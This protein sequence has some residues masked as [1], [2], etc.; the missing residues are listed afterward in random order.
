MKQLQEFARATYTPFGYSFLAA[1]PEEQVPIPDLRTIGDARLSRPSPDLLETI[2][3]CQSRQA[4]YHD[5]ALMEGGGPLPFVGSVAIG[6]H[7][8]RAATSMRAG[9]GFELEEQA[10]AKSWNDALRSLAR[11]AEEIGILVMTNGVVGSNTHR[12]LDPAEFR[13]FALVDPIAPVVFVNGADTKAAQMF[14]LAHELAHVWAGATALSDVSA[15]EPAEATVER[16]CNAVAAELLVPLAALRGVVSP[17]IGES[18]DEAVLDAAKLLAQRFKVSTLV[19]LRRLFEAEYLAQ[20]RMWSI[21][22]REH[23]RLVAASKRSQG[24]GDYYASKPVRVSRRFAEAIYVSAWE[25]RASFTEAMRLL[26]I[27]KM[28]TFQELGAR[29]GIQV[30]AAGAGDAA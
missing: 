7:V 23:A 15:S 21:Y 10:R 2:Y 4:W 14:T 22:R 1:P 8:V 24:G 25:G 18:D 26:N 16:W 11:H 19:A 13:G 20:D 5:H 28:A 29:L 17:S 27:K 6:S 30:E 12:R 3:T 9:L